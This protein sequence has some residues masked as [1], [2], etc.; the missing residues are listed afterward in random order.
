MSCGAGAPTFRLLD[1]FVGWDELSVKNLTGL[2]DAAGL[3]LAQEVSGALDPFAVLTYL[4]PPR[5][6]RGCGPCEWYLVTPK[7]PASKLLRLD[8]CTNKWLPVWGESCD[9]RLFIDPIAVAA[10]SHHIAVADR[11]AKRVW[12]WANGGEKI[13]AEISIDDPGLIAFTP[14]G[15]LL[16]SVRGQTE[17]LRFGLIG[18][19]RGKLKAMSPGEVD[20]IAVS[21]DCIIWLVTREQDGTL[22]L[23]SAARQD[24]EFKAASIED[25]AKSFKPTGLIA[26]SDK[27]FCLQEHGADGLPLTCCWSWYGRPLCDTGIEKPSAPPLYAQ[28]QLLTELIDSGIPRCR[29]HRVRIDAD[30]PPG[31]SLSVAV[32]TSET[33]DPPDQGNSTLDPVWKDFQPGKPHPTD[34]SSSPQG[35]LDFLIDQPAGRYLFLRLRLTGD[36][37]STP[38]VRR[39]RLD[40]PRA[41]SLDFLPPVY[42]EQPEAE[43][44]TERFLSLFDAS[45]AD[46]DRAIERA[47]ALLDADGVPD[48]LLPW[49]GSFLD[50]VFDTAWE[51]QR[52]R[53]ILKAVPELYRRRGTVAGLK[54]AINLLFDVDAAIQE[55]STERNWGGLSYNSR[56]GAVRL[57]G[58]SRARFRLGGSKL[59]GAPVKSFGNADHDP[60]FAQ[61]YRFR[62]M[63][64]PGSLLTQAGRERLERLVTS[65]KPAH[66]VVSIHVGGKGLLLGYQSAVG[67]DTLLAPLEPPVLGVNSWLRRMSVLQ[68]GPRG[69][70]AGVTPGATAV[71]GEMTLVQ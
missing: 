39:I 69:R 4:P 31:T 70:R 56:L 28:G 23:W 67:V 17:I 49:L 64:P 37:K 43:D 6:A 54:K 22:R 25:L 65:Q 41:T 48:E 20:W 51:P 10:R 19:S 45:I 61:A 24:E 62:V 21:E 9:P 8:P 38:V 34:W 42:R 14:W 44:F 68:P 36:K 71:V 3:R 57:F 59:G 32:A 47:P 55:L 33:S 13:I 50:V 18:D 52:R 40:F 5:L 12:I 29:W 35:S 16:V 15:E 11:G 2:D 53:S 30:M 26:A 7:P 63:V 1:A 46:L 60:L 58:K 66:T 27:G